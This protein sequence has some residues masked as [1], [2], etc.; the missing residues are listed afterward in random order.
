MR[1]QNLTFIQMQDN[2][3]NFAAGNPSF[4][5][6]TRMRVRL[7]VDCALMQPTCN[8]TTLPKWQIVS[9]I[10]DRGAQRVSHVYCKVRRGPFTT[11]LGMQWQNPPM[12]PDALNWG[13]T[14]HCWGDNACPAYWRRVQRPV[15]MSIR[16]VGG[17]VADMQ[18]KP[19][20]R[21]TTKVSNKRQYVFSSK[22]ERDQEDIGTLLTDLVRGQMNRCILSRL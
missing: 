14:S 11:V 16:L 2:A 13:T 9:D 20:D 21:S 4:S 5:T 6:D 17:Q 3:V 18:Q 7:K 10:Q 22:L 1:E 19:V 8:S 12:S 15:R